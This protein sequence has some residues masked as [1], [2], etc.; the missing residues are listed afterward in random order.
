MRILFTTRSS[1]SRVRGARQPVRAVLIELLQV[2]HERCACDGGTA[3]RVLCRS[4]VV[5]VEGCPRPCNF[6]GSRPATGQRDRE[7]NEVLDRGST[8]RR[9]YKVQNRFGRSA[10]HASFN[11]PP[12]SDTPAR[13][14]IYTTRTRPSFFG[15]HIQNLALHIDDRHHRVRNDS[16]EAVRPTISSFDDEAPVRR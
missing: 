8:V 15:P 14:R 11:P 6:L 1:S 10:A 3:A 16:P 5:I 7:P 9:G 2:D 4:F 12:W 13:H